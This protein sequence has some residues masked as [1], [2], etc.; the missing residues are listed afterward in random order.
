[1]ERA[2]TQSLMPTS[3]QEHLCLQ[4]R[5]LPFLELRRMRKISSFLPQKLAMPLMEILL[6]S[7]FQ[8][9]AGERAEKVR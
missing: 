4:L 5:A 9:K 7:S 3:S 1:M 2:V 8:P 6:P